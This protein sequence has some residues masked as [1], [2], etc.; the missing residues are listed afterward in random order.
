MT[1]TGDG[2]ERARLVRKTPLPPKEASA[3]I[4]VHFNPASLQY[5]ITNTL[6]NKGSGNSKKQYV[7]QS[8]GKLTFDLVFD[9]THNGEDVRLYT[10]K[11]AKLMEPRTLLALTGS[12]EIR[13][14]RQA[15]ATV[16]SPWMP[17]WHMKPGSTRKNSMS[18]K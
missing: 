17:N 12:S 6:E 10:G 14:S 8:S 9:T 5:T 18:L 7:T 1:T 2:I 3:E 15:A 11:V 13:A 4:P 16:G